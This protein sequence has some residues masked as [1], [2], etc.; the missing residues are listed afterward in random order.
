MGSFSA[1]WMCAFTSDS[2]VFIELSLVDSTTASVLSTLLKIMLNL[3]CNVYCLCAC[4]YLC[5][6]MYIYVCVCVCA[7]HKLLF[8]TSFV[9]RFDILDQILCLCMYVCM[10][11]IQC[12]SYFSFDPTGKA[13]EEQ[14]LCC[15]GGQGVGVCQGKRLLTNQYTFTCIYIHTYIHTCMHADYSIPCICT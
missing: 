9:H 8:S 6:C 15:G 4:V 12:C 13:R 1:D 3:L 14:R 5:V 2:N 11:V 7:M 10:Y